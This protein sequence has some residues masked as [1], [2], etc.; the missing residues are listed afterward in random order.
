MLGVLRA[1]EPLSDG[2]AALLERFI[3]SF[4]RRAAAVDDKLNEE[5]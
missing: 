2:D 1:R 3:G 4:E 5:K